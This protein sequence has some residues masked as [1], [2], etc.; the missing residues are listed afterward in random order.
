MTPP[1]LELFR[2]HIRRRLKRE[3]VQ[4]I[5]GRQPFRKL[6]LKVDHRALIPR[7]E[8]EVLAGAV[9]AWLTERAL[10]GRA[11]VLDLGTGTGAL[12]LSLAQEGGCTVTATDISAE[13]LELARENVAKNDLGEQV[14]LRHGDLWGPIGEHEVFDVIVSNPPY[15]AESERP[16]LA[17]EVVD[18]EPAGALFAQ[19]DGLAILSAIIK[20][21]PAH[22]RAGGLLALEMG[23]SQGATVI[24][25]LK[26][27]GRYATPRL[28][29]DLAGRDRIV[30]AEAV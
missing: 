29:R 16:S 24:D 19:G 7:P 17:P 8:T 3:P 22:L 30:L 11:A 21:A 25:V 18:Y 5:L 2:A 14:M 12:A 28:V 23:A 15:V 27:T 6:D 4:Y 20:G 10:A 1:E 26:A 9:L 13:S